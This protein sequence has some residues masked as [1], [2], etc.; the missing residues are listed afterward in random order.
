MNENK[1]NINW[2]PG[3]MEKTKRELAKIM[4]IVDIV[5]EI[6][7]ARIPYSS[8]IKDIDHLIKNKKRILIMSK[9]DLCDLSI[10]NKWVKYYEEK[11]YNVLL[12]DLNDNNDYKKILNLTNE[13]VKEI[14]EKRMQ[15]GLKGKYFKFMRLLTGKKTILEMPAQRRIRA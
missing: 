6:I 3:H 5:Y 15:K 10:T 11:G 2:Y 14:N 4:P 1:T 12:I 8:K 7:D 9:K 13:L